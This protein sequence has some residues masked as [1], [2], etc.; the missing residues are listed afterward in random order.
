MGDILKKEENKK[1]GRES[2]LLRL[3]KELYEEANDY[4]H[5]KKKEKGRGYSLNKYISELVHN[6]L[7]NRG[8]K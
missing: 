6:D 4:V 7:K 3:D 2:F 8:N 5:M 1:N